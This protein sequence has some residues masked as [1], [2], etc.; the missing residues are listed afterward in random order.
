MSEALVPLGPGPDG[1]LVKVPAAPMPS[2]EVSGGG[3]FGLQMQMAKQYPRDLQRFQQ[4]VMMT[5]EDP[6]TAAECFYSKPAGGGEMVEGPSVRLAEIV[7][8]AWGNLHVKQAIE[9]VAPTDKMV[10]AKAT[11]WDLESNTVVE[12]EEPR[13]IMGRRGRFSDSMIVNTAKAARSIAYREAIFKVVPRA[14]VKFF[15]RQAR[16]IVDESGELGVKI[17][18]AVVHFKKHDVEEERILKTLGL[19]DWSQATERVVSTLRGMATALKE[20]HSV[21]EV[22]PVGEGEAPEGGTF[23]SFGGKKKS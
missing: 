22:F 5:I 15:E 2:P 8:T 9:P 17:Q 19:Q 12:L 20:G 18:E 1:S 4:M 16:T 7:A 11:V 21:D 13:S 6:A 10:T 3:Q 23:K 14:M